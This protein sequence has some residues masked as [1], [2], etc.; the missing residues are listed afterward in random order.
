M[1][2]LSPLFILP[3]LAVLKIATASSS[4]EYLRPQIHLTPE[5]G[6]AND[7]NGLYYDR[8]EKLWH[9]YYQHNPDEKSIWLSPISW[10]HSTSKDLLTWDYHGS[11]IEAANDDEGIFSGSIV[12]DRNNTSGFF[13]DSIDPEQ[14]VVAIYTNNAP[15]AQTQ[16]IAYSLDA[17]YSFVK[18][19]DNPVIDV[20][21]TQQRDPKVIWHEDS[22]QW[23]MV[24]AK[25]QEY[26]IQ[27]YASPDL[28]EWEL[29]SNFTK[30]GYLGFQ[31]E[32]P[33]LFEL[34]I[35]NPL[36]ETITHKWVMI[37]AI[38]P[39]SPL[40]G[41][42]NEYF[43][44]DF[45]GEQ[46]IPDDGA[47]RFMD[48]GKD[49]YAFQA[50]DNVL[51]EDGVLGLAW[52]S[53]WQYAN[54]VPTETWR[55]SMS[56]VRNYTLRYVDVNPEHAELTLIQTPVFDTTETRANDTLKTV[57]TVNEF[58]VSDVELDSS[59]SI[60]TDF[61][62]G[63]NSSGVLDFD[64]K[65][66][67]TDLDIGYENDTTTFGI[68]IHSQTV[69]GSQETLQIVFDALSTTWY[70]D[71]TTQHT[72]QRNSPIFTERLSTYV[73][74]ID[75]TD[76]GN[77]YTLYGVVDRNILELYFN[78]GSIVMTNTFFFSEGKIPSSIEVVTDSTKSF[79][80]IDDLVIRELGYK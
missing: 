60:I 4:D 34:P 7:P 23:I 41:S 2:Q 59:S 29:K 49:F 66:T 46:F 40:G 58:D 71:R 33:G 28:K 74:M 56:L 48:I 72:F 8:K 14:R 43:V 77:V 1:I 31:Y 9:A 68:Y 26:K 67:H 75:S 39:G 54:K 36:N 17:G 3:L 70:V 78:D 15:D 44:G 24:V 45:D 65:F 52:A 12:V 16:E 73:Q 10:G 11:A 55:S 13:N 19:E 21:S 32:C 80:T 27:I 38:N 6:W 22:E 51:P 57:Q 61:N 30:N 37:L 50:F 42:I 35:E 62:S 53:N 25:S 63:R 5:I 79:I 20:K 47:S 18:Y 76:D 69:K 64:L